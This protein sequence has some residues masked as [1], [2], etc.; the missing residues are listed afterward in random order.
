MSTKRWKYDITFSFFLKISAIQIEPK[1]KVMDEV[2]SL[3]YSQVVS[4]KLLYKE[5]GRVLFKYTSIRESWR[6][7]RV[8]NATN[9]Y[10]E[11]KFCVQLIAFIDNILR[12]NLALQLLSIM[13][14]ISILRNFFVIYHLFS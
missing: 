3:I 14:Q 13:F 2:L 6:D 1:L 9:L 4:T 10:I 8:C 5:D 7:Y 12:E 11:G